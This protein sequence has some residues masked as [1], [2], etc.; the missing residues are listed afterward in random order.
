MI[1]YNVFLNSFVVPLWLLLQWFYRLRSCPPC[2]HNNR[3]VVYH[4]VYPLIQDYL[5]VRREKWQKILYNHFFNNWG[6]EENTVL[7][8]LF[9]F[10]FFFFISSTEFGKDTNWVPMDQNHVGSISLLAWSQIR[11][12][13]LT[14]NICF[15]F[16]RKGKRWIN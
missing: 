6:S 9:S 8:S 12:R 2:K 13:Y 7:S 10:F 1:N 14:Y 5:I 15:F 16:L 3:K 4:L 11:V